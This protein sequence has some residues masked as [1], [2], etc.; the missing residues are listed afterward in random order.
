LVVGTVAALVGHKD[1]PTLLEAAARVRKKIDNVT[2]CA[3]G[4]GPD[5]AK[6]ESLRARLGLPVIEITI[7]NPWDVL[8]AGTI[9]KIINR[10]NS[11]I[12]HVHSS[13]ALSLGLLVKIRL[14][15]LILVAS[16]RVDFPVRKPVFG[17]LKYNNRLV[18][19]IICVSRNIADVLKRDGVDE[20][21]LTVIRSGIDLSRF[22]R[23]PVKPDLKRALGIPQDNLVV[24][25][26][27]ALVGHKDYPTLLEA[28]ARVRKKIDNVTFCAVGEG[29]D[30]AK[31]ESLRA[32]LGLDK[33]F[34]FAG[35]HKAIADYYNLFDVFVLA[36]RMEGLGTATL[37]AMSCGIPVVATAAGGIPEIVSDGSNGLLVPTGNPDSLADAITKVLQDSD[38]RARL[39][40]GAR[41]T[42]QGFSVEKTVEDH[43]NLYQEL[44]NEVAD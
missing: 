21:R 17:S 13:H 27:A 19:R 35:F 20:S 16:R 9:A 28:A 10:N 18:N 8:A 33:H 38:L 43:I 23:R 7:R 40:A 3:V 24:G 4:E 14:R 41:I 39:A 37:E 29:P 30:R 25:T 12:L 5:R 44:L 6:L 34:L 1:Y 36:S 26:V 15:H 22:S 2:F 42:A 31:L 32:R 11:Q